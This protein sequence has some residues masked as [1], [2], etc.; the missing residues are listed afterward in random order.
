[1]SA[2]LHTPA[3][4]PLGNDYQVPT[5]HKVIWTLW[6]NET[7]LSP[8]GSRTPITRSAITACFHGIQKLGGGCDST[9][10]I[11]SY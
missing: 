2:Q 11:P 4:F 5:G 10:L 6:K 9:L 8:A 7:S 3:K 1:M